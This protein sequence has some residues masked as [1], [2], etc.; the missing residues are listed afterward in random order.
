MKVT[1]LNGREYNLDLKKY[2]KNDRS[3]QSFY[4]IQARDIIHD[5]FLGYNIL[6][7]VKLPG[8]VKPAKKSVLYLDFF[9]PNASIAVE[10]H[11]QQHFKYTPFFHK[12]KAGFLQSQA[13]DRDKAEWCDINNIELVVLRHD[14]SQEYWRE[15]LERRR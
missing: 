1:G 15:Q 4:H 13:R 10:V 9:I 2:M 6:E 11:G 8:S 14:S 5:I 7:E 12:S 3:K